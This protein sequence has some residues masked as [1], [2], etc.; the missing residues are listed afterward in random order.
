MQPNDNHTELIKALY[1]HLFA[2]INQA[3]NKANQ[4]HGP[5]WRQL[6]I[7]TEQTKYAAARQTYTKPRYAIRV[8]T[9]KTVFTRTTPTIIYI[10]KIIYIKPYK[11]K[12]QEVNHT[13][14]SMT[15]E[16]EP[17]ARVARGP[18]QILEFQHFEWTD[19][20]IIQ[21]LEQTIENWLEI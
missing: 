13:L 11:T 1:Q 2:H 19:P 10:D 8:A 14:D 9:N 7:K 5:H 4:K 21:K 16:E 17:S 12:S 18:L 3:N 20:Q 6:E 15:S